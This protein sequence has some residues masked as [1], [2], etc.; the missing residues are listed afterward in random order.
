M[1][2]TTHHLEIQSVFSIASYALLVIGLVICFFNASQWRVG[3]RIAMVIMATGLALA[4]IKKLLLAQYL[5]G[6]FGDLS[7]STLCL[8]LFSVCC[9]LRGESARRYHE[10]KKRIYTFLVVAGILLYPMSTGLTVF[11]PYA[12]GYAPRYFGV[13]LLGFALYCAWKKYTL[14]LSVLT[15]VVFA[16]SLDILPS[17]NLWDYLI[18]PL[19][20]LYA[21]VWLII[22]AIISFFGS[23][24][25]CKISRKQS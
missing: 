1:V 20:F 2:T 11:D 9:F 16:Y 7:I 8:L 15:C 14:A 21:L 12:L 6:F 5:H 13:V 25:S 17:R 19:V 18:D 3:T 22:T 23:L 24:S 10:E 4:P